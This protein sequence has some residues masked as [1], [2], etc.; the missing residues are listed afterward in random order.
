MT[1]EQNLDDL[2]EGHGRDIARYRIFCEPSDGR[3]GLDPSLVLFSSFF[4]SSSS[5]PYDT[6]SQPSFSGPRS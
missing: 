4:F 3:G 6:C 5:Y 2:D 1:N